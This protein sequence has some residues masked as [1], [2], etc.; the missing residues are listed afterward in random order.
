MSKEPRAHA[1]AWTLQL[2]GA[3]GLA[4][5]LGGALSDVALPRLGGGTGRACQ[6]AVSGLATCSVPGLAGSIERGW[7]KE[8]G[9]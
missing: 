2:A 8:L 7:W 5:P 3:A 1:G 6:P 9:C 4:R